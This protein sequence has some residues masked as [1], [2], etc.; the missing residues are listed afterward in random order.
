MMLQQHQRKPSAEDDVADEAHMLVV[1]CLKALA[2]ANRLFRRAG[3]C[4]AAR[5]WEANC[6]RQSEGGVDTERTDAS[7]PR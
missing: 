6:R 1:N 7:K 4:W 3:H 5:G 2:R